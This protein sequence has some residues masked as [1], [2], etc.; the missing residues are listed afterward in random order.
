M[1]RLSTVRVGLHA[2]CT[3]MVNCGWV[4][5]EMGKE[6]LRALEGLDDITGGHCELQSLNNRALSHPL[7]SFP[8]AFA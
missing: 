6:G 8:T 5:G 1:L 3:A 2:R 4:W 7:R